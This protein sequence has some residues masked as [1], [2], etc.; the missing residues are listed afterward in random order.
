M[1]RASGRG[2][3]A[4]W[5]VLVV[6]LSA[7]AVRTPPPPGAARFADGPDRVGHHDYTIVYG[8]AGAPRRLA[9]RV[10][11]PRDDDAAHPLVVYSHGYWS[12][13]EGG[14]YL[15]QTLARRGYVVAAPNH[16]L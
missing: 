2:R 14:A 1:P 3:I 9:T 13:R 15:A 16:P 6:V 5:T 7:C 4:R 11:F 8:P 10:W 12:T